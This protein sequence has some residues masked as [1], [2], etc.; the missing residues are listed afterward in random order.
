M[1]RILFIGCVWPEPNSSAAGTRILQLIELFQEQAYEVTFASTAM[2]SEYSFPLHSIDVKTEQILL[3]DTRF[4]TFIVDINP[5]IVLFDRLMTEEQFSWRVA[6]NC[7]NALR[8]LDLEDLHCLRSARQKAVQKNIPFEIDFIKKEELAKREIA[9]VLRSDLTL[10][11]SEFE[12]QLLQE[13][14]SID[15]SLLFYLPLFAEILSEKQQVQLPKFDERSDFVFIGN[16]LHAP[17]WDAVLQLKK[18]IWPLI[19]KE[20]P[21]VNLE[22]YGAYTPEKARQLH[23]KKE[24]FLVKGRAENTQHVIQNT[25]VLLAPLR[26]GAGIKG[27][28]INAMEFGTPSVTTS[29]GA[30]GM[31]GDLPWNG[32]ISDDEKLFSKHAIALYSDES[33]WKV[34]QENGFHLLQKRF[35]KVNFTTEFQQKLVVLNSRLEEYRNQNFL[36]ELLRHHTLN[37]SKYFSKWIEEKNR[38]EE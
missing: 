35:S 16:F 1:K 27:K 32:F 25:R 28:L 37:S 30:E 9:S 11:I 14:F 23:N 22:I 36:G 17:N 26:F 38:K 6:E 12:M 4:D 2:E 8:I 24:G 18:T 3:N 20:L 33:T 13:H 19:R 34:S 15:T 7:P 5:E 31:N 29:I 10:V 21:E